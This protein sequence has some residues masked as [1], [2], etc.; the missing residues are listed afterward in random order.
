MGKRF[1]VPI[2]N[3]WFAMCFADELV[4]GQVKP[5][6]YFARELVRSA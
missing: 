5:L 2:P 4:A 3:G 1:P 6:R